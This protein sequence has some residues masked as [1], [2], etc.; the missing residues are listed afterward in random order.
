MGI[1]RIMPHFSDEDLARFALHADLCKVLTDP[2][3]VMLLNALCD[4]ERTVSELAELLG[5]SLPNV[6]QHLGVMRAAGFVETRRAG[7]TIHYRLAE[8]AI[9]EACSIVDGIA[10][11]RLGQGAAAARPIAL[12]AGSSTPEPA[13]A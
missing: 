13:S 10:R 4:T 12:P 2:K 7:T 6:S 5:C 9:V 8:P 11:R 3:R 1:I